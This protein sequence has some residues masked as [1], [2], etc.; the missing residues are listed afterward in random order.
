MTKI[1]IKYIVSERKKEFLP[2]YNNGSKWDSKEMGVNK[3]WY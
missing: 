3:T 2:N 1:I